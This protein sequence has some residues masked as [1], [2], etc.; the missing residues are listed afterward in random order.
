[1]AIAFLSYIFTKYCTVWIFACLLLA[2][3]DN[4]SKNVIILTSES[5]KSQNSKAVRRAS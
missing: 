5:D 1:M 3:L 2:K 4:E